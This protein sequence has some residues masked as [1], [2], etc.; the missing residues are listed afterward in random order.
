MIGVVIYNHKSIKKTSKLFLILLMLTSFY[1]VSAKDDV[2]QVKLT[3][4]DNY[5]V[6]INFLE[7]AWPDRLSGTYTK[8]AVTKDM[9]IPSAAVDVS[10]KQDGSIKAWIDNDTVYIG[11]KFIIY[12][13]ADSSYLFSRNFDV[14]EI[15]FGEDSI[16]SKFSTN[17]NCMFYNT[18]R[19]ASTFNLNISGWNT[20]KLTSLN[21]IFYYTGYSAS[22]F[23]ITIPQTNGN[24]IN[25]STNRL[26][27]ST[28]SYYANPPTGVS[29]RQFTLVEET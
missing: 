22:T 26:Y 18:G 17:L 2:I 27:G 9:E 7:N 10:E 1:K 15:K 28:S 12:A 14:D 24:G 23:S 5:A 25:N 6:H 29:T 3:L 4:D 8:I 16:S 19:N 13:P 21:S 11:S 20:S